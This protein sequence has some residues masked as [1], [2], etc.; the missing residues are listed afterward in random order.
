MEK[1]VQ[2]PNEMGHSE[3]E[4]KDQLIYLIIKSHD[5][6]EK[7]CYPSL[8]CIA[9]ESN[10]SVP[11]IRASIRR[12]EKEKYITVKKKGRKNYYYFNPYK[13][14]EPFTESFIKRKDLTPTTKAYL[15]AIQQYMY[16]DI[17]GLGKLSLSN[18]EI[19]KNI[20]TSEFTV[21]KCNNELERNNYLTIVKNFSR[22]VET[23]CSTETK[24]FKL[25][26]LG[27]A[28]IWKLKEHAEQINENTERIN[29]LEK[30]V[31]S[32]K[33]LIELLLKEQ[34]KEKNSFIL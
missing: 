28:I 31:N 12:L 1:H 11:T 25:A 5:N 7:E 14:F 9:N 4:I 30:I 22:D 15:V 17:E 26:E 21:R 32:Q 19:A 2:L 34:T 29:N 33:K 20:N 24:V 27:Q 3:L 16:K 18:R 10:M 23:G 13:K 6:P 8:E